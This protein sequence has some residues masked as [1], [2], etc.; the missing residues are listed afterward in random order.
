MKKKSFILYADFIQQIEMLSDEEA[1]QLI[2]AI[3]RY[4]AEDEPLNTDNRVLAMMFTS[5]T[6]NI[7]RDK[8]KYSVACERNRESANKRWRKFKELQEECKRLQLNTNECERIQPHASA[9]NR[10]SSNTLECERMR[11]DY[12]NDSDNDSDNDND[13]GNTSSTIDSTFVLDNNNILKEENKKENT[14]TSIKEKSTATDVATLLQ[15]RK[16]KFYDSLVPFVEL[17]GKNLIRNFFDYWTEPNKSQTKMRYEL[18]RTWDV[19]RRLRT[20]AS[21][22][23]NYNQRNYESIRKE[24]SQTRATEAATL[25]ARLAAEDDA[26]KVR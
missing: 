5:I 2:K 6:Q 23:K 19:K 26:R 22:D 13:N 24:Q 1:G 11:M 21:R 18:E 15:K 20:W 3:Y 17:Y 14:L 9:Y 7:E 8:A 16:D 4:V 25:I 10:I 12:D